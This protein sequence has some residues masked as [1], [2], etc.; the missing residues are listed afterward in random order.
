MTTEDTSSQH[1]GEPGGTGSAPGGGTPKGTTAGYGTD[2]YSFPLY[3]ARDGHILG[4]VAAGLARYL[5]LDV[6]LVRIVIVALGVLGGLG[7]PLYLAAWLLVPE[8]ATGRCVLADLLH[9]QAAL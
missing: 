6:S 3:R 4:G 9:P 5:D 1:E 8:E 2:Q 7:I